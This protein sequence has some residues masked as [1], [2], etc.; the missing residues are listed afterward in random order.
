MNVID[1]KHGT[2]LLEH[3]GEHGDYA[4][5]TVDSPVKVFVDELETNL[6]GNGTFADQICDLYMATLKKVRAPRMYLDE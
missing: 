6:I 2:L 3:Y 5:A 1:L 4:E